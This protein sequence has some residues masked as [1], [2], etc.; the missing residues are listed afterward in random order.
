MWLLILVTVHNSHSLHLS[1][2]SKS[3]SSASSASSTSSS[4]SS[5]SSTRVTSYQI[6]PKN[7]D[8]HLI[9]AID[10]PLPVD[11]VEWSPL[12]APVRSAVHSSAPVSSR[13]LV[14]SLPQHLSIKRFL[15][16]SIRP[17]SSLGSFRSSVLPMPAIG[18]VRYPVFSLSANGKEEILRKGTSLISPRVRVFAR[19]LR[20][21]L[22][23][24]ESHPKASKVVRFVSDVTGE[25]IGLVVNQ[26]FRA[27][28]ELAGHAVSDGV[29][30]VVVSSLSHVINMRK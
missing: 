8:L 30:H 29:K 18:D 15:L 13:S 1:S 7:D 20:N 19:L 16:P 17:I 2:S 22:H 9:E 14:P 26:R 10:S 28:G 23:A 3:S 21:I 11:S 5:S 4:P 27:L 12:S 6:S 24:D 25:I